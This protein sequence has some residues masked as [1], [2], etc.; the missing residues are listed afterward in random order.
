M[1]VSGRDT[2]SNP[3]R[4]VEVGYCFWFMTIQVNTQGLITVLDV[5]NVLDIRFIYISRVSL[6]VLE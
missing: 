5:A 1:A 2:F 3:A 4:S 6:L